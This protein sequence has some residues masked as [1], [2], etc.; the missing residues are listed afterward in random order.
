MSGR[1]AQL[2]PPRLAMPEAIVFYSYVSI[3]VAVT[4][5]LALERDWAED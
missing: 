2:S 1:T 5:W 4:A 3:L